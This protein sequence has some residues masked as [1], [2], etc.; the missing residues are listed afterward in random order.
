[1]SFDW[2]RCLPKRNNGV[3]RRSICGRSYGVTG[4]ELAITFS[5]SWFIL[6]LFP[7]LKAVVRKT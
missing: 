4:W 7:T 5:L 6:S 2:S 1:M 3:K